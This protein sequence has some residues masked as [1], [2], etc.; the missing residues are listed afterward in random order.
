MDFIYYDAIKWELKSRE[1]TGKEGSSSNACSVTFSFAV[2]GVWYIGSFYSSSSV[3]YFGS[4][5]YTGYV[6][7]N[8]LTTSFTNIDGFGGRYNSYSSQYMYFKKSSNNKTIYW[9][10]YIYGST[11]PSHLDSANYIYYF[12]GIS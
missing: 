10:S 8:K 9:Y 12:L 1:G 7:M 3:G 6:N 11:S 4:N 2:S 5:E